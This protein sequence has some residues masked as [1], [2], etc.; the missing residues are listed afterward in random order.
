IGGMAF[1]QPAND[2]C[3][4]AEPITDLDGTCNSFSNVG[5]TATNPYIP[6]CFGNTNITWF[7]FV[8]DGPNAD[9]TVSG[10]NRPEVAIIGLDQAGG[11]DLCDINDVVSY[12]CA[13]LGGNYSSVTLTVDNNSLIPGDTYLIAVANNTGGGGGSGTFDLCV[14]NPENNSPSTCANAQPFCTED[15]D[16]EYDAGVDDGVA[17]PGNDYDCLLSQPNPA[18]FFLEID[19]PGDLDLSFT[20]NPA[21]DIDF[22]AWG[23]FTDQATACDNLTA[24]NVVDCSFLAATSETASI[25]GTQ[26]GEVYVVMITNFSNNPTEIT[27]SQT[28]GNATTNCA[29]VLPVELISFEGS[30]YDKVN[31]L[32][33]TTA[34]EENNSHFII[35]HSSDG[36]TWNEIDQING[37]G[38]SS[39]EITYNTT[40]RNF[41]GGINY[42]RLKQVDFDGTINKH[43]IISIDNSESLKLLKRVNAIGQEVNENY[44][45]IVF[46]YYNDGSTQKV[47]Q[48]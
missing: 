21:E 36:E 24:A 45:G 29:I 12:G 14:D 5:A 44:K 34:S 1:A 39:S 8:A 16:V 40:H 10:I 25:T 13:S 7:S 26:T 33:W 30:E 35:E 3:D 28:G 38:N 42:Y 47:M 27:F 43:N 20:S 11:T 15:G 17:E 9:I 6:P 31:D 46:E 48:K 23:P 2:L 32:W 22:A 4:N 18:W 41:E 37:A 19:D